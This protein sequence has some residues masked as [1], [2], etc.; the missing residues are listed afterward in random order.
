MA[1]A[2]VGIREDFQKQ[3]L[4]GILTL[5]SP[6]AGGTDGWHKMLPQE[7]TYLLCSPGWQ[8]CPGWAQLTAACQ[9]NLGRRQPPDKGYL[10]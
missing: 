8:F 5:G 2:Q 3:S 6:L 7:G 10:L 4:P 9:G 1:G